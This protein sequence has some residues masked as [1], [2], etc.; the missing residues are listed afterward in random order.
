MACRI[1][2]CISM[3]PNISLLDETNIAGITAAD[4]VFKC[5]VGVRNVRNVGFAGK[6]AQAQ[7]TEKNIVVD[8]T[9]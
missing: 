2:C 6:Q 4:L 5:V 1:G 9:G 3:T 7:G 8:G